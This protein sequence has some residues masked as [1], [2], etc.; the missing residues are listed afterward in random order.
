MLTP[1]FRSKIIDF[2]S[3]SIVPGKAVWVFHL[4]VICLSDD[5]SLLDSC[6][7]SAVG[8]LKN[9][10]IYQTIVGEKG[11]VKID[12]SMHISKIS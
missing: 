7:L 4:T 3:M 2:N 1:F 10:K 12:R 8:A 11:V 6:L 5:G 9:T